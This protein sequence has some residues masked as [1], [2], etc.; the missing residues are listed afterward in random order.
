MS[1]T[2]KA[3]L[4]LTYV[5]KL[6]R[7]FSAWPHDQPKHRVGFLFFLWGLG[8]TCCL[9]YCQCLSEIRWSSHICKWSAHGIWSLL[10]SVQ[11]TL[12]SLR[13][14]TFPS[15]TNMS[16]RWYPL[17]VF[18]LFVWIWALQTGQQIEW[19]TQQPSI[20]TALHTE[21][22]KSNLIWIHWSANISIACGQ[23]VITV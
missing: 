10:D 8:Q 13:R 21:K 9:N 12:G 19:M 7:A 15:L 2:W 14:E 4:N 5:H 18:P 3:T 22:G 1:T 16:R 23:A 20:K 17:V 6:V 11:I